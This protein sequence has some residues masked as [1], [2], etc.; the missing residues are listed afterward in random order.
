MTLQGTDIGLYLST[1]LGAAGSSLA[2]TDPTL[3]LGKY[4]SLTP[5][6]S[7]QVGALF[8]T[9]TASQA[10]S[11]Y[12]QYRC[13]AVRN[14]SATDPMTNASVFL[15]DVA[16]GGT[17][18]VGLDPV[19]IVAYNSAGAQGTSI[20]AV[21]SAPAGVTFTTP[22][23]LSVLSIG[24]MAIGTVQLVWVKQIVGANTPGASADPVTLSIRS[25][26]V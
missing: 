4:A 16:G 10:T 21:T 23:S 26:T 20:A 14:L 1:T 18:A 19:G 2:Q 8:S 11:G 15:A 13:V 22:T 9:V 5:L 17:Y 6:T 3:S 7:G 12:T 24:T 25:E